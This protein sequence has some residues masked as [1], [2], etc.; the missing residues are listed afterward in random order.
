MS[1]KRGVDAC[2]LLQPKDEN[3]VCLGLGLNNP[4]LFSPES[5][6][7]HTE[8]SH[9]FKSAKFFAGCLMLDKFVKY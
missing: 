8:P 3:F 5:S 1:V 4:V 6:D 9:L 2:M 7:L